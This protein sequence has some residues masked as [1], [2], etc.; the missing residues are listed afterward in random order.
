MVTKCREIMAEGQ[1]ARVLSH[2]RNS[3][4]KQS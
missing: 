4:R 1:Q 2:E 3:Y